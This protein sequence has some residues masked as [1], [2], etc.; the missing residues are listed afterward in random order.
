MNMIVSII[1]P[2]F[3]KK[4]VFELFFTSLIKFLTVESEIIIVNDGSGEHVS[5]TIDKVLYDSDNKYI[6]KVEIVVNKHPGGT[7]EAWNSGLQRVQ[8]EVII[9]CDSDIF[10]DRPW[11]EPLLTVVQ[12]EDVGAVGGVLVYPQTGGIQCCGLAFNDD[13]GRHLMLNSNPSELGEAPFLVQA[14]VF[15]LCAI[16]T[17]VVRKIGILDNNYFN[18]YEDL[19]YQMRIIAQGLK[20]YTHPNVMVLH[21]ERSNGIHRANNRKKNLGRFWRK[22]GHLIQSDMWKFLY[23][24]IEKSIASNNINT[25]FEY[26]MIDLCED[27]TECLEIRNKLVE[28]PGVKIDYITDYSYLI[29]NMDEI[30]LPQVLGVDEYRNQK[31]FIFMVQNFVKLLG[32]RYWI[33]NRQ[34]VQPND[35]IID[36]YA[37]VVPLKMLL[38]SCWP[39]NKV[40]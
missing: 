29:N 21:W 18:G 13:I 35:I 22:Y 38:S 9:F 34:A 6:N 11:M 31:P 12:Q 24:N 30:W 7:A 17:E 14:Q 16:R 15:A 10:F 26:I 20:I 33:E 40:R 2:V 27:R 3:Q 5:T 32:N 28:H 37:N 23:K 39:G 1:V 4:E 8:G 19:D 25:S 36:L